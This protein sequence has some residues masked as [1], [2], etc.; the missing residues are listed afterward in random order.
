MRFDAMMLAEFFARA[1]GVEIAEGDEFQAV[2]LMIPLE[3][4]LEHQFR[5]AIGLI[6]RCGKSSVIGTLSGGP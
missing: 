1:G 6:G 4:F 3:N 5:F 2:N